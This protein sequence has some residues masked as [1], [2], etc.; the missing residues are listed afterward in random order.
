MKGLSAYIF[1]NIEDVANLTEYDEVRD[2]KN[3][4]YYFIAHFRMY[5]KFKKLKNQNFSSNS[6]KKQF[7]RM[8][9]NKFSFTNIYLN[10]I[11][12]KGHKLR[13]LKHF[14]LAVDIMEESL[15]SKSEFFLEKF[16]YFGLVYEF[17]FDNYEFEINFVLDHIFHLN[18][19]LFNL[20]MYKKPK[21]KK[22]KK[23]KGLK[24]KKYTMVF[25]YAKPVK[26]SSF[27]IK[28][29]V[30]YSNKFNYTVLGERILASLLT[31]LLEQKDSILFKK[32]IY[33][34]TK[35][36]TNALQGN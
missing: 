5:G 26:R 9:L 34:Y 12:K 16:K 22:S 20:F 4:L 31:I 29:L 18:Y 15:L 32:K 14:N 30:L 17:L 3:M 27:F 11:F 13:A 24:R 8:F 28:D 33:V 35:F 10:N 2:E 36:V 1:Y 7:K 6:E 25:K 19:M 21:K 23:I